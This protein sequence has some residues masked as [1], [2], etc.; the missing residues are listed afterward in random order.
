M[1]KATA[2]LIVASLFCCVGCSIDRRLA[3]EFVKSSQSASAML[4]MTD[5]LDK[6]NARF[7]FPDSI[8]DT[9][10]VVT[11][12]SIINSKIRVI[13]KL[14]DAIVFDVFR[15]SFERCL[16][17][18]YG[19]AIRDFEVEAITP[20]S[21]HW[22]FYVP[23][24]ELEES[25]SQSTYWRYKLLTD[26]YDEETADVVNVNCAVWTEIND[27]EWGRVQFMEHNVEESF[28]GF[29]APA[30][31]LSVSDVYSLSAYMGRLCASFS[32]DYLLNKYIADKLAKKGLKTTRFFRYNPFE[33]Y[34]TFTEDDRFTELD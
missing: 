18:E 8:A 29:S 21:L 22:V 6:V 23:R 24:L 13:N 7:D 15:N 16:K 3:N 34:F 5:Y 9:M 20:D 11:R 19:I 17:D 2:F 32:Y 25:K 31:T 27:G 1:S 28:T 30:D 12:D 4:Y 14:E 26:S 33:G 10:N